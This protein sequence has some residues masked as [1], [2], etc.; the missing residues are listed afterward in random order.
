M[1][2]ICGNVYVTQVAFGAKGVHALCVFIEAR[3]S[4]NYRLLA[5]YRPK[6]EDESLPRAVDTTPARTSVAKRSHGMHESKTAPGDA[7]RGQEP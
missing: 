2:M 7:G 4:S 1:V 6:C 5:L 3:S